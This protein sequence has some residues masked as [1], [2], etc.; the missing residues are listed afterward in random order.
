MF[1]KLINF[2]FTN[3]YYNFYLIYRIVQYKKYAGFDYSDVGPSPREIMYSL[4]KA[5]KKCIIAFK[6]SKQKRLT[7][8]T[9]FTKDERRAIHL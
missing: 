1:I 6:E 2:C 8:S 9:E 3:R 5:V 4:Q 7:F